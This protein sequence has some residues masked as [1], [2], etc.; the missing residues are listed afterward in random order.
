MRARRTA[1]EQQRELQALFQTPATQ[2]RSPLFTVSSRFHTPKRHSNKQAAPRKE[3]QHS[4]LT[5]IW[6][7]SRMFAA[8]EAAAAPTLVCC[9]AFAFALVMAVATI[10]AAV[11]TE[12]S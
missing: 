6:P 4:T 5:L 9:V 1:Q 3:H 10:T 12:C 7:G 8:R 11:D 2:Q